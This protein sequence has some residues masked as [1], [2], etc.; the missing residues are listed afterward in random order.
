MDREPARFLAAYEFSLPSGQDGNVAWS[1][2]LGREKKSI[3]HFDIAVWPSMAAVRRRRNPSFSRVVRTKGRE[4]LMCSGSGVPRSLVRKLCSSSCPLPGGSSAP[5]ASSERS[6]SRRELSLAHSSCVGNPGVG[7]Q[8]RLLCSS[9]FYI[10][11]G[12]LDIYTYTRCIC[13]WAS[14]PQCEGSG[15]TAPGAAKG[16][17]VR[18][19]GRS[20]RRGR[21]MMAGAVGAEAGPWR[22]GMAPSPVCVRLRARSRTSSRPMPF[23]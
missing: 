9:L 2:Q 22:S 11:L 17:H 21:G 20:R 13:G 14:C 3:T 23:A 19:R 12:Y 10:Q 8:R 16:H 18:W 6:S 5:P 1:V 15:E 4:R 7:C